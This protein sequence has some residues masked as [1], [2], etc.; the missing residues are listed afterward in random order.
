MAEKGCEAGQVD[1]RKPA[2]Q[3][4]S[5]LKVVNVPAVPTP[6]HIKDFMAWEDES[7]NSSFVIRGTWNNDRSKS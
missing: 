7:R 3:R 1:G 5:T 2:R 6:Q 4:K